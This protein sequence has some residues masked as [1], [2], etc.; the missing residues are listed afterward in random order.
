[1]DLVCTPYPRHVGSA[2][3][4]IRAAGA[5]RPVIGSSFGW[6]K[7]AIERFSLGRTCDVENIPAL[8]G[9]LESGL[10]SAGDFVLSPKAERWVRYHTPENFALTWTVRLRQRLGL[11]AA[12]A[13][14]SWD[15]VES[16]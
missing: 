4:V 12:P 6:V 9:T 15:W 2:S 7:W 16:D 1:M 5:R 3:I 14:H 8:A 10:E 13:L 11:A